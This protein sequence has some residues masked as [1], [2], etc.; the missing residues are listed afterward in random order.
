VSKLCRRAKKEG[1]REGGKEGGRANSY[2]IGNKDIGLAGWVFEHHNPP[3]IQIVRAHRRVSPLP[4]LGDMLKCHLVLLV[5]IRLLLSSSSSS[6]SRSKGE[7][8]A[9]ATPS[10]GQDTRERGQAALS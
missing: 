7:G 8:E 2:R 1:G 10:Q 4:L 9:V 3:R 5:E 6:S